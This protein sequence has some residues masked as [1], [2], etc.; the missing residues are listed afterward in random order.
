MEQTHVGKYEVKPIHKDL[1]DWSVMK[2]KIRA[3]TESDVSAM[4]EIW[5]EVSMTE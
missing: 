3:Y 1:G 2:I 5:N 4:T